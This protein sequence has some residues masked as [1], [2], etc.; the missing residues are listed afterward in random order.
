MLFFKRTQ[1]VTLS[2]L[3]NLFS[4]LFL[5]FILTLFVSLLFGGVQLSFSDFFQTENSAILYNIRLPRLLADFMVGGSLSI[6]GMAFQTFFRNPLADPY[7]LGISGAAAIGV[8]ISLLIGLDL[9]VYRQLLSF[10]FAM[11]T[12]FIIYT[13]SCGINKITINAL[14]LIG[15][16]LNFF[17]AS[18]ITFFNAVMSDKFTKN[19]L[20]WYMGDTT[21]L[22]LHTVIIVLSIV[23]VFS[24]ILYMESP[25]LNI[26]LLGDEITTTSGINI[27]RL[28]LKIYIISSIITALTVSLCGAIGFV[29]IIVPHI[30]KIIFGMDHRINMLS[31]FFMGGI[32]VIIVDTFFKVLCYPYEVPLGAITAIIG[33]PVFLYLVRHKI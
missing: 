2:Y 8:V 17:F 14:I 23:I 32:F 28:S 20:M 22:D 5:I 18:V 25:K 33:T 16:G 13:F 30:V 15:V 7:I 27:N 29:G 11:T 1:K 21:L 24:F 26:Y 6:V 3:F 9:I 4:F 31:A 12:I 19:I 10:L